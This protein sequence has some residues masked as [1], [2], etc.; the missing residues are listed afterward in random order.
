[1]SDKLERD[2]KYGA[3]LKKTR[4]SGKPKKKKFAVN[5]IGGEKNCTISKNKVIGGHFKGFKPN[6][7][8]NF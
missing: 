8:E 2:K 6:F 5:K 3:K 7:S 4:F 1:M